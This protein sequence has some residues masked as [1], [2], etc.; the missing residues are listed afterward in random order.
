LHGKVLILFLPYSSQLSEGRAPPTS[1]SPAL[2]SAQRG[3]HQRQLR[4]QAWH[5]APH[6]AEPTLPGDPGAG[7]HLKAGWKIG[8]KSW[9]VSRNC[10]LSILWHSN[11]LISFLILP[12]LPFSGF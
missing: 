6:G 9:N 3:L 4:H 2:A 12:F 11:E 10:V 1:P 7:V 8:K 5:S